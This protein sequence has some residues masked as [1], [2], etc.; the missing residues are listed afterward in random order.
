LTLPCHNLE[1]ERDF[2]IPED[3]YK[4]RQEGASA[5]IRT[6]GNERWI[7]PAVES[8]LDV[9]DEVVVTI[10]PSGDRTLDILKAFHSPKIKIYKYPF[11]LLPVATEDSIHSGAYYT[12]W[13]ISKTHFTHV[14]HWDDDMILL[15][16]WLDKGFIIPFNIVRFAGYDVVTPDFK[17]ISKSDRSDSPK[18]A[19]LADVRI[20]RV[21]KHLHAIWNDRL[22]ERGLKHPGKYSFNAIMDRF[23]YYSNTIDIIDPRLWYYYPHVQ[24][25][26]IRNLFTSSDFAFA[27]PIY[28]HVKYLKDWKGR[29]V[30]QADDASADPSSEKGKPMPVDVPDFVF[31]SPED[32]LH[33]D[34][35]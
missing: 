13:T 19:K 24:V 2:D 23:N 8:I 21:N 30:T 35:D 6:K 31:K 10:D 32:Y 11:Y 12:N 3:W 5:Y 20:F 4:D 14:C 7:G 33:A 17:Y 26:H 15:P 29:Y 18:L 9:F 16:G 34:A 28:L 27:K 1:G 22:Y 25:Q